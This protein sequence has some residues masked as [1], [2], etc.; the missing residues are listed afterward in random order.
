M[1]EKKIMEN[2]NIRSVVGIQQ[3]LGWE[4]QH[5]ALREYLLY[6]FLGPSFL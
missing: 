2:L 4:Y 5:T 3:E 6:I 1:V